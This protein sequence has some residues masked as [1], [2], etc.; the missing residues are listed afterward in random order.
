M[1]AA[2][3]YISF[4][5]WRPLFGPLEDWPLAL[6]DYRSLDPMRDL[7]PSDNIYSHV[8]RE[9]YNVI[10]NDKHRWYFLDRQREDEVL[11]FKTFDTKATKSHARGK[12]AVFRLFSN[13]LKEA[14]YVDSQVHA[15][16]CPHAAF[17]DPTAP[18][19]PRPRA[20]LECQ[21]CVIYPEGSAMDSSYEEVRNAA[22]RLEYVS[23]LLLSLWLVKDRLERDLERHI[24]LLR[25]IMVFTK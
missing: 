23:N 20:S 1:R 11:L 19:N 24:S 13:F 15:S 16:V 10:H 6:L 14:R 2:D 5:V 8:I 9:T 25:S 22:L 7:V 18:L 17:Q 3:C 4:S 21:A 12:N